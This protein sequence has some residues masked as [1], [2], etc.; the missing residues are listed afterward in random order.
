MII[1]DLYRDLFEFSSG[2][3][4][5]AVNWETQKKNEERKKRNEKIEAREKDPETLDGI[6]DLGNSGVW[7]A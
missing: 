5:I 3:S 1:N 4:E 2:A 7:S 6:L